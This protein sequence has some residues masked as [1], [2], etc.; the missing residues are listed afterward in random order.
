MMIQ[1]PGNSDEGSQ[2]DS[3]S[4]DSSS[5]GRSASLPALE[6]PR[7]R[8]A[9]RHGVRKIIGSTPIG[10]RRISREVRAQFGGMSPETAKSHCRHLERQVSRKLQKAVSGSNGTCEAEG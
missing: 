7:M 2:S 3:D 4:S 9:T 10:K 5:S 6:D 8:Y 1:N